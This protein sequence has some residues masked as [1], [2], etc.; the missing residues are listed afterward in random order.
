MLAGE[1]VCVCNE[2][3]DHCEVQQC[4]REVCACVSTGWLQ[5]VGF[6]KFQISVAEYRLF[7]RA[8]L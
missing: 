7:Y 8:L 4:E 2:G 6:L 5:L 1:G 3:Q